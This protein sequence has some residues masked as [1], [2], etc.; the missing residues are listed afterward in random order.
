MQGHI[1]GSEKIYLPPIIKAPIIK[2]ENLGSMSGANPPDYKGSDYQ[3]FPI[4]GGGG[5]TS[6]SPRTRH[7]PWSYNAP[8]HGMCST[9]GEGL[10]VPTPAVDFSTPGEVAGGD[11][12]PHT[13]P[14]ERLVL[15]MKRK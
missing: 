4:I 13:D 5:V 2:V 1:L 14:R 11:R 12:R 9:A 7:L 10:R 8:W 15:Y 3:A 6:P